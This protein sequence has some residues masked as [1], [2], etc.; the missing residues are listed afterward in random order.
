MS[1]ED[2]LVQFGKGCSKVP[3]VLRRKS[4]SVSR[5][6]FVVE[7]QMHRGRPSRKE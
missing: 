1:S 6:I 3:M 4:S 5:R 2:S 7:L